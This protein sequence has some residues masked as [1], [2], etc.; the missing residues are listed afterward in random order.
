MEKI[1]HRENLSGGKSYFKCNTHFI[2]TLRQEL[3]CSLLASTTAG[4]TS[5]ADTL[6]NLSSIIIY[7]YQNLWYDNSKAVLMQM[8]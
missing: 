1:D 7:I 3:I 4:A 8:L 6:L 2:F 5:S